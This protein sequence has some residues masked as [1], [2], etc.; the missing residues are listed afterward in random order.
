[1]F[2]GHLFSYLDGL[3]TGPRGFSGTIGEAL[4]TCDKN[5]VVRFEPTKAREPLCSINV[6]D[7]STDQKYLNAVCLAVTFSQFHDDLEYKNL[8]NICQS[9]WLTL[10]NRVLRPSKKNFTLVRLENHTQLNNKL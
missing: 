8:G 10:A 4:H 1:M 6:D 5:P 7:L 3:T 2:L 9:Q